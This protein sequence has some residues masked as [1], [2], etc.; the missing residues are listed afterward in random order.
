MRLFSYIVRSDSG[1]APNPYHGYCTL[2]CCKP[3]IRRNARQGDWVVGISSKKSGN[4]LIFAMQITESPQTFKEY[5][6]D[7]R[8]KSK[9]PRKRSKQYEFR[10][11]DNI[12]KP[13]RNGTFLQLPSNH[14]NPD[15][16]ENHQKKMKDLN[17]K[18]VLISNKF[19]YFGNNMKKLPDNLSFL[20]VGRG[21]RSKFPY[22]LR[23]I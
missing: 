12:Y 5:Y 17:G 14:S 9:K 2:A 22:R 16:S 3:V 10:R 20:I 4:K 19:W 21:H 8:F 7:P 23:I 1:F 15:G 6:T 13:L 18:F 11:G